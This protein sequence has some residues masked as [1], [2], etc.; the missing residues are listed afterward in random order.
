MGVFSL[1]E[2]MLRGDL[3]ALLKYLKE[4]CSQVGT[5]LSYHVSS[6]RMRGNSLKLCPG[7]V[8]LDNKKKFTLKQLYWHKLAIRCPGLW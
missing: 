8:R 6:D 7:R 1:E 5:S 3:T 4:G 2:R